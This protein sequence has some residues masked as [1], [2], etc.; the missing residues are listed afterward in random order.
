MHF[1]SKA[2]E[3]FGTASVYKL[4]LGVV[5]VISPFNFPIA[6]ALRP[7][8]AAIAAG[9]TVVLKPSE[10][11][12][13]ASTVLADTLAEFPP[14][15]IVVVEGDARVSTALL[16]E[17]YNHVFYTGSP[18]IG[19]VI[20]TAAAQHLTPVTLELGGKCP[21]VILDDSP[22]IK[23]VAEAVA[24]SKWLNAGQ[25][26]L[27]VD[28]ILVTPAVKDAF[29]AA[30]KAAIPA[31][32]GEHPSKSP[33]YSR[34]INTNH[35]NR[36]I[37]MIKHTDGKL[38]YKSIDANSHDEK[39]I[40]PHVYEVTAEDKLM[41][42][43]I[44]GPLVSILTVEDLDAAIKFIN[45]GEKP[46]AAYVWTTDEKKV[47]RFF[48]EVHSGNSVSNA[49]MTNYWSIQIPFG[50]VGESGIGR[51]HGKYGFDTFTHEKGVIRTPL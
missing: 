27:S 50:G 4:P 46:L 32:Y 25:V 40:G 49:L 47:E 44:F 20:M 24:K 23:K 30:L 26:C 22:D 11:S 45:K 14:E 2:D 31:V 3:P 17:R 6:L 35:F 42:D 18:A 43:E 8:S 48:Q 34:M 12:E 15:L 41:D 29:I 19:R 9:N 33:L 1:K 5:L 16:E 36:V 39:F 10:N 38:L 7:L 21:C 13:N 51:Y 28:Y 37:N